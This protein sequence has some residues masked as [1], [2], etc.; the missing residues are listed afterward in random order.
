M[1]ISNELPLLLENARNSME[2]FRDNSRTRITAFTSKSLDADRLF[3]LIDQSLT[4]L[5]NDGKRRKPSTSRV[6]PLG[7]SPGEDENLDKIIQ[8][9]QVEYEETKFD[10]GENDSAKI[11]VGVLVWAKLMG[12]PWFPAEVKLNFSVFLIHTQ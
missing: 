12:F 6:A 2:T 10:G 4:A 9:L 1:K 3:S 5:Q 11:D 8:K 7:I